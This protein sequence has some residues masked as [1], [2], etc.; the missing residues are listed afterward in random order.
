[1][2]ELGFVKYFTEAG[3]MS[4][5][6]GEKPPNAGLRTAGLL[7]SI[8]TLLIVSPLLGFFL[9]NALDRRPRTAPWFCIV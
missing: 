3:T 5:P 6:P 2:V 8:P 9:G 7:L 1:L 4:S